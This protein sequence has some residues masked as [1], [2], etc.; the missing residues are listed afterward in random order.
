MGKTPLSSLL[1]SRNGLFANLLI[2][3]KA[4]ELERAECNFGKRPQ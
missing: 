1:R 2:R 4:L 3:A